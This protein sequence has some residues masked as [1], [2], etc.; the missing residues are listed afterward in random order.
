MFTNIRIRPINEDQLSTKLDTDQTLGR[1]G[2]QEATRPEG[3]EEDTVH[4]VRWSTSF[5]ASLISLLG[6]DTRPHL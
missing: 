3:I 2:Q 5:D 6:P 4:N 1:T